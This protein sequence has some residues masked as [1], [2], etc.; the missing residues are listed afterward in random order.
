MNTYPFHQ[1]TARKWTKVVDI[2]NA[3]ADEWTYIDTFP[4]R[5]PTL[6]VRNLSSTKKCWMTWGHSPY[7]L[8]LNDA[9]SNYID[10]STALKVPVTTYNQ[11]AI[12]LRFVPENISTTPLLSIGIPHASN[13]NK[14]TLAI[15]TSGQLVA[16]FI[17]TAVTLWQMT[18]PV[19]LVAGREYAVKL[20]HDGVRPGLQVQDARQ[21]AYDRHFGVEP[22]YNTTT[23]LTGWLDDFTAVA[24]NVK[25]Y[26]GCAFSGASI[27]SYGHFDVLDMDFDLGWGLTRITYP[28]I[29]VSGGASLT[30]VNDETLTSG[31]AGSTNG[32]WGNRYPGKRIDAGTEWAPEAEDVPFGKL[33]LRQETASTSQEIEL[34]VPQMR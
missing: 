3:T 22:L 20:Y 19:P 9:S 7:K 28:M 30:V 12:T 4:P 21:A 27:D 25:V 31:F 16:T 13:H 34:L 10:L 32:T 5:L 15:N 26:V 11:G 2:N 23:D 29:K 33:W 1:Q 6:E 8:T 24:T 18:W 14:L 17:N